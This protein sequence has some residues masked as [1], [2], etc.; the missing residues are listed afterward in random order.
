MNIHA[1]IEFVAGDDWEIVATLLDENGF[2]YDLSGSPTVKWRLIASSG[3]PVIGD[4]AII[5]FPDA[6]HG[7]CSVK[8]SNTVTSPVIGG[9]YYDALRLVMG[10][11]V[12]TLL[13]G[14]ISVIANPWLL[15]EQPQAQR[16]QILKVVETPRLLKYQR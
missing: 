8:V 11:E 15:A 7:V 1:P 12:G 16:T 13:M 6:I 2:P 10:G 14:E 9:R 5:T 3:L 4:A